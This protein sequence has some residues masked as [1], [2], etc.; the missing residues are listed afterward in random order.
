MF[1]P[2]LPW[3]VLL[4]PTGAIWGS[5]TLMCIESG[6]RTAGK[7]ALP[8]SH[9]HPII[10]SNSYI[11]QSKK[12]VK[13]CDVTV[14]FVPITSEETFQNDA[15]KKLKLKFVISDWMSND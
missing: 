13:N 15:Y 2:K 3:E 9:G 1:L 6:D 7:T 10:N 12:V 5:E 14:L 11:Y 4:W 8:Q